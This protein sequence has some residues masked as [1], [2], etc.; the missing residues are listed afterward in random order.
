[1]KEATEA[2]AVGKHA[3][4]MMG[5]IGK[6]NWLQSQFNALQKGGASR[7]ISSNEGK[8]P[9]VTPD[10][11]KAAGYRELAGFDVNGGPRCERAYI[12]PDNAIVLVVWQRGE[13]KTR[14]PKCGMFTREKLEAW[15]VRRT[16]NKRFH[17]RLGIE[18]RR[19]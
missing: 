3:T 4:A 18:P 1:M 14:R 13:F 2:K 15:I 19:F 17:R 10:A 8:P 9:T 11:L 7:A 6:D 12:R 16:I 5:M